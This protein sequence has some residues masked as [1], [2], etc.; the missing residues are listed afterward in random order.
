[1]EQYARVSSFSTSDP[2]VL[3]SSDSKN[4]ALISSHPSHQWR[5]GLAMPKIEQGYRRI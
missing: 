1:M 4:R 2:H 5:L 3:T